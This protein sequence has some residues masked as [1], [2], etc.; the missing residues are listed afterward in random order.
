MFIL[1]N[2]INKLINYIYNLSMTI[3][4]NLEMLHAMYDAVDINHININYPVLA[5]CPMILQLPILIPQVPVP[6]P[7]PVP[8]T[9]LP[10][11]DE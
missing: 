11:D 9:A 3:S 8:V 1:K 5:P 6:I 7:V 4:H 2:L 10:A